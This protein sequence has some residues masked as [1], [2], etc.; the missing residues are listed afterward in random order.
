MSNIKLPLQDV[1]DRI[2][3][4]IEASS[5]DQSVETKISDN[6]NDYEY[7]LNP[8][9]MLKMSSKKFEAG[10][11]VWSVGLAEIHGYDKQQV[12]FLFDYTIEIPTPEALDGHV[13]KVLELFKT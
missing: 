9:V 6:L 5:I 13:L 2:K 1:I 12:D 11:H 10:V 3:H 7:R 4:L 8:S